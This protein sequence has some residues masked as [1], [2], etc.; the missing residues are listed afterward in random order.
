MRF[1]SREFR[2]PRRLNNTSH[3]TRPIGTRPGLHARRYLGH[4]VRVG[5]PSLRKANVESSTTGSVFPRLSAVWSNRARL[6]RGW[7]KRFASRTYTRRCPCSLEGQT[8]CENTF[9]KRVSRGANIH[10]RSIREAPRGNNDPTP[11]ERGGREKGDEKK[12]KHSSREGTCIPVIAGILPASHD[13]NDWRD[14]AD[15]LGL[16]WPRRV[17]LARSGANTTQ[18][19]YFA[20]GGLAVPRKTF[21]TKWT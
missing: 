12:S 4:A 20:G 17:G 21:Q 2:R 7:G 19:S 14:I 10:A 6:D 16:G 9:R 8:H 13:V 5:T 1:A 11:R 18:R 3:R 15:V